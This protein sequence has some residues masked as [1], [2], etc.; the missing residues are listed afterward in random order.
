MFGARSLKAKNDNKNIQ[1]RIFPS[2][3]TITLYKLWTD[4]AL[5]GS[6]FPHV[7]N[8]IIDWGR[9]VYLIGGM[10]IKSYG[11]ILIM[12]AI[13]QF[14][15][16]V[17]KG[18][19]ECLVCYHLVSWFI[20]ISLGVILDRFFGF[21]SHHKTTAFSGKKDLYVLCIHVSVYT[22]KISHSLLGPMQTYND[23]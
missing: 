20:S 19:G 18:I 2:F 16:T 23:K 11:D 4:H 12:I 9:C 5:P 8:L 22:F 13:L 21:R 7:G 15:L 17:G 3:I 6:A 14:R 1:R 10:H